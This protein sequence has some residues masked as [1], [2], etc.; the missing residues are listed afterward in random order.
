[1]QF[2]GNIGPLAGQPSR[3][4]RPVPRAPAEINAHTPGTINADAD[5]ARL[6]TIVGGF[7]ADFL[8]LRASFCCA[9][10]TSGPRV[11]LN[12]TPLRTRSNKRP[13]KNSANKSSAKSNLVILF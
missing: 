12:I 3:H 2:L 7:P 5:N 4:A 10:V 9:N 1:M 6:I 11:T 8:A 13:Y